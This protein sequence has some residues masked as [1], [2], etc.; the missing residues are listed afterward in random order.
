MAALPAHS[1]HRAPLLHALSDELPSSAAAPLLHASPSYI[2]DC[3]R[4]N[5]DSSDLF[6]QKYQPGTHRARLSADIYAAVFNFLA[7]ACAPLTSHGAYKQFVKDD[8]LFQEYLDSRP[9][10]QTQ[11]HFASRVGFPFSFAHRY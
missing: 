4:K 9:E 7:E 8:D 10:G 6:T 5:Y 11:T 2:R 3:K 1:H